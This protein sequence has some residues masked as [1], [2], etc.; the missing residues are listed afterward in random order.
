MLKESDREL[1]SIIRP[2]NSVLGWG[3]GRSQRGRLVREALVLVHSNYQQQAQERSEQE[4]PRRTEERIKETAPGLTTS[5]CFVK[6]RF[7]MHFGC[8]LNLFVFF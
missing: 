1:S 3:T 7:R 2:I 5:L 8:K 6:P 4:E